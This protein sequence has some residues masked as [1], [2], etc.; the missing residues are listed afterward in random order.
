MN[1]PTGSNPDSIKCPGCGELIPITETLRHQ[2]TEQTRAE[3][4]REFAEVQNSLAAKDKDLKSRETKLLAA[5]ENIERQVEERLAAE[6]VCLKQAALQRAREEVAVQISDLEEAAKD[7]DE[8]L[9]VAQGNELLL[10]QEK[11][12]LEDARRTLELDVARKIDAERDRIREDAAAETLESYRLRDAE[13]DRKLH[14][15][16]KVNDELRRKLEQG[17]QQT[18]G[19][20]LEVELERLLQTS[21]PFDEIL[22]VRKGVTGADVL[23]KVRTKTGASCGSILWETK[24]TK[25]WSDAWIDKLKDDQ[26]E[27]KADITVLVTDGLPK[28][29]DGFG[30]RDGVWI[31]S[32]RNALGVMTALRQTLVEVAFA[33]AATAGK[34]QTVEALFAYL[35]GPEFRHRVEAIVRGFIHMRTDLDEEKRIATRRWARREKQLDLIIG[36]TSGMYGGLQGLIGTSM[37]P[38]P[39]LEAG[40]SEPESQLE[41]GEA[42][43]GS[44]DASTE[45]DV[46]F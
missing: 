41:F 35:T 44:T 24:N 20:V 9:Q 8:K 21:C 4:R 37:Q 46:P 33:K 39:A 31:A 19:E 18:Q 32:P 27:A 22:P 17:S 5:A 2:L 7:K 16:L 12:V 43:P 26:R 3:L 6:R 10:R 11:R 23:Q 25:N 34:N 13:K 29:I 14:E 15:A 36:N 45:D 42:E 40:E 28:E 30:F 1:Q 38:I